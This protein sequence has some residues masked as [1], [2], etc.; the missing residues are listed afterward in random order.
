MFYHLELTQTY[1][2]TSC[3]TC[4]GKCVLSQRERDRG[5]AGAPDGGCG[6]YR[7]EC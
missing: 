2:S 6:D 7:A 1:N 5:S 3:V 4:D